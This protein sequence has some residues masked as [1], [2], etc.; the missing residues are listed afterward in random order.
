MWWS[1]DGNDV[2]VHYLFKG[3][4]V[5]WSCHG[6]YYTCTDYLFFK[7]R[8]YPTI[9]DGIPCVYLFPQLL[10]PGKYLGLRDR[11]ASCFLENQSL[12]ALHWLGN[13]LK[14]HLQYLDIGHV[15]DSPMVLE[16]KLKPCYK[17]SNGKG[18]TRWVKVLHSNGHG[19]SQGR[20]YISS[21]PLFP[22]R[23][24]DPY[25]IL[26]YP[27]HKHFP[28]APSHTLGLGDGHRILKPNRERPDAIPI[29]PSQG[30]QQTP[31]QKEEDS[32]LIH[33]F[34]KDSGRYN[35]PKKG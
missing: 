6:A 32:T 12:R 20:R 5:H 31:N 4:F 3:F 27:T 34:W 26:V 33:W 9:R 8:V 18:I 10:E 24:W 19:S 14:I 7:M 15:R 17:C 21:L 22:H 13:S 28:L 30:H 23:R 25:K 16:C 1:K 11:R 29:A 2:F 35:F